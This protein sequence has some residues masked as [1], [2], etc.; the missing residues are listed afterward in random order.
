MIVSRFLLVSLKIDSILEETTKYQRRKKLDEVASGGDME[1]AYSAT[2][3]RLRVQAPS[4]ARLG[5][6]AIM[7][8]A[9]SERPLQEGELCYAM[10]VERECPDFKFDNVPSIRA[11]LGYALGLVTLDSTSSTV[12][13]V[14]FTLQEYLN[15]N[16]TLFDN[17]HSMIAEG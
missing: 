8:V 15:A 16:P 7:W 10:G 4:R 17:P 6:D 11:L 12:R 2:L 9:H 1:D 5:M 14:H 3:E 13:L